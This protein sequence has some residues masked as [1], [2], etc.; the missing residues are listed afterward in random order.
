MESRVRA[1]ARGH[2]HDFL[3]HERAPQRLLGAQEVDRLLARHGRR[4]LLAEAGHALARALLG[5][6]GALLVDLGR[7][8]ARL[9]DDAHDA[10]SDLAESVRDE[11]QPVRA[12]LA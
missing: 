3:A 8:L 12:A 9:G 7:L 6:L 10:L 1:L 5:L 2:A 4:A 11:E